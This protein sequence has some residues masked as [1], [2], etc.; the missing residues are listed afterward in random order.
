VSSILVVEDDDDIRELVIIRL[1]QAGHEARGAASGEEALGILQV[2]ATPDVLV[3]DV[4]LP[5]ITGFD[6]VPEVRARPG[7]HDLPVIFLSARVLGEDIAEGRRLGATYLT[8]PFVATAL[9]QA[10]EAALI[11]PDDC[12]P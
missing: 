1:E 2:P 10:V 7:C 8:K 4:G 6:L 12:R 9:L 5:D 11:E 3:L